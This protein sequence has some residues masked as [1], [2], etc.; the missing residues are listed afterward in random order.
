MRVAILTVSDLGAAGKREDTS[1]AAI[2]AWATE[3]GH[4]VA[5][6]EIVPDESDQIAGV[7][8]RWADDGEADLILTTGGTGLSPRDVTPEATDAVIEREVP[9]I[10]EAIRAHGLKQTPR[11]ALSRGL[12][13]IRAKALIINLPGSPNGVKDGLAVIEPMVEHAVQL[14]NEK[15]TDHS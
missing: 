3:K 11:S 7:L 8:C 9:G 10:A 5:A 2:A 13:G 1:G 12:A 15:P 6:R 4:T 14:L